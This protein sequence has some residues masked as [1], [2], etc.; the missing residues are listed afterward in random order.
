MWFMSKTNYNVKTTQTLMFKFRNYFEGLHIY[1]CPDQN[2]LKMELTCTVTTVSC[3]TGKSCLP[4]LCTNS[5]GTVIKI[6]YAI[7]MLSEFDSHTIGSIT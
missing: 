1:M 7:L 3:K 6:L 2:T 4:L 5:S